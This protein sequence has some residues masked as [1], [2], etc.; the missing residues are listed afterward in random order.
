MTWRVTF[1]TSSRNPTNPEEPEEEGGAS[2]A[3]TDKA[4]QAATSASSEGTP[5]RLPLN[6]K[7]GRPPEVVPEVR[8]S[9]PEAASFRSH[10]ER[11][12]SATSS[13]QGSRTTIHPR[14]ASSPGDRPRNPLR[15]FGDRTT[16]C[17]PTPRCVDQGIVWA[18]PFP[19]R[20]DAPSGSAKST[21][22]PWDAHPEAS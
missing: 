2:S 5:S 19:I 11:R 17:A 18:N 14:I 22:P 3:G 9:A 20:T 12:N 13:S 15:P 10:G 6:S 8:T 21:R 7:A 16:E 1:P 4:A